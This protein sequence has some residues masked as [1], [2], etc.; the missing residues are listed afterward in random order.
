MTA[1]LSHIFLSFST[2][3]LLCYFSCLLKI[4]GAFQLQMIPKM[5]MGF[6][7]LIVAVMIA[8]SL[9]I[10][11]TLGTTVGGNTIQSYGS[12]PLMLN[13]PLH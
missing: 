6:D 13:W 8:T 10:N 11:D 9:L 4:T 7:M 3:V 5:E 2:A 1:L 12:S